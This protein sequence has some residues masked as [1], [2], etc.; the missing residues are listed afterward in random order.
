MEAGGKPSQRHPPQQELPP[1]LLTFNPNFVPLQDPNF[2]MHT[3]TNALLQQNFP[4]LNPNFPILNPNFLLPQQQQELP[5]QRQL[6]YRQQHHQEPPPP[7]APPPPPQEQPKQQQEP[8]TLQ[9]N[10]P[11]F[12]QNSKKKVKQ[13]N[14]E[15]QLERVDR[16]VEKARQDFSD[17]EENVSAWKV[18]QSVLVNFQAESWDSLGFKMQE[19]PALF[20]LMVTESKINAFIHC[21]VGVRRITS[22]YDLEVAICKN[23]GIEDFEELGLGPFDETPTVKGPEMLGVRIQSLGTHI[24]FIREAKASENSTQKK[25]RETLASNGSLKKCQEARA[26]GPRVQYDLRGVK[27]V[28]PQRR[29]NWKNVFLLSE[30][31]KS[32]DGMNEDEMT[33]NNVGSHLRSSAKAISSSDRVSSCPYPSATEEMSRLGLKGEMGSQFPPDCDSTRPKESSRSFLKKRKLE[34]VS[35]NVSV[36]SKL[37]GSNEKHVHPIDNFDKTEE[38]VAPSED[39]ISLSSSSLRAFITTWK[40]ACKDHTVAEI[41][42]RMLQCYK[43]T[44][45]KKADRKK[46]SRCMRRFKCIFSSYPFN[47]MLNVAVASIKCG[48]WDSIYDTFQVTSQPESANTLSGNCFEYGCIDVEPGEKQAPVACERLQQT[49]RVPVEEIIG[50]VTRHYELHSEYQSNG[51]SVLENK[52]IS[53]K[54]LFSCELWLADQFG[55][56]EFKSLGHGEFF[57]FLEKHASLFPAKLQNHL[58]VDRCGKSTLEVS[59]LQHQL[60]V[61]V[62]Q[63]SYSLWENEKI[64]KQMVA[65]LLTRQFPLL[66]FNIMENGSID[67]FQQIVGKYKNNVISKCVLFSA[68]LSGMHHI[69]DSLSRKED[70]ME[71]NE[72]RNKGDNLVAAFNSITSRDAVEVLHRAPMLSDLNSWSHWDLKFA[73]VP[74]PSIRMVVE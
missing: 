17:A 62:S 46:T 13:N 69:G 44:E 65:A 47:G 66:S 4:M 9:Q 72:V 53:M 32:D 10:L 5:P 19:V 30:D 15:L 42:E 52:L 73:P 18:S 22:I 48:M 40:E 74:W 12:P 31:E 1:E 6:Q 49:H 3:F 29:S 2:F 39:D 14:K 35:W 50:K 16:A 57:V 55:V 27:G 7:G 23:E 8:A 20:R 51:K 68:T 58:S 28:F 70:K 36:P 56:K 67:D 25:C 63:A 64:T 11:K 43:P 26:S 33:N 54:K 71:S 61:L 59:M 34:D 21:F 45:S 38:F 41:L 37:L 24:S 60:M